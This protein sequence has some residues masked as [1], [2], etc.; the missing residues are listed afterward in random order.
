MNPI[1][2]LKQWRE[3]KDIEKLVNTERKR[4]NKEVIGKGKIKEAVK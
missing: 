4:I 3:A 2:W 1:K